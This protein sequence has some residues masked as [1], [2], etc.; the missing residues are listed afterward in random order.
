MDQFF[1]KLAQA[2]SDALSVRERLIYCFG[3]PEFRNASGKNNCA[4]AAHADL[5]G[6]VWIVK[7]A[8]SGRRCRSVAEQG[9]QLWAPVLCFLG[10]PGL[11]LRPYAAPGKYRQQ[12]PPW[13]VA[14]HDRYRSNKGPTS[15][16]FFSIFFFLPLLLS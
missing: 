9:S 2:L 1:S 4:G 16:P 3:M 10:Q 5:I 12:Q 8:K 15:G 7:F 13:E 6:D 11:R 14:D